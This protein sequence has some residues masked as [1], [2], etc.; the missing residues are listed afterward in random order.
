MDTH[1]TVWVAG[2]TL[3]L[4]VG[5][6][7][8]FLVGSR[9]SKAKRRELQQALNVQSVDLLE[10]RKEYRELSRYLGAAKRKDRLLKFALGKLK[11]SSATVKSLQS[12]STN[13]ERRHFIEKSR[14][15]VSAAES[16]QR[17]SR[18]T[19]RARDATYRLRLLEKAL[20]HLQT[21][22]A[23]EPKSYGQGEAVTVSVVDQHAPK[24]RRDKLIPVSNRDIQRLSNLKPSNEQKRDR[25]SNAVA[26][27]ATPPA[28]DSDPKVAPS[29]QALNNEETADSAN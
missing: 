11:T 21:I 13:V 15:Q 24:A 17:E 20:P 7:V 6:C 12:E 5:T 1:T 28:D 18:A 19:A 3:A 9:R 16:K 23:P 10:L 29:G 14:L 25:S 2:C 26:L 22:T 27:L 4:L 8:G